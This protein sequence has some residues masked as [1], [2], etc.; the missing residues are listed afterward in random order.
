MDDRTWERYG[1]LGGVWF[2]VMAVIGG[3]FAGSS[4]GRS[5]S[6]AD[7]VEY[8]TDN[9]SGLGMSQLQSMAQ[10]GGVPAVRNNHERWERVVEA[11]IATGRIERTRRNGRGGGETLLPC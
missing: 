8:Y 4:P 9:D 6:T 11:A 10:T 5:D 2:V 3:I 7:I 1:A